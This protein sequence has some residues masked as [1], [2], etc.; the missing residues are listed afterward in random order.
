VALQNTRGV[1]ASRSEDI[2]IGGGVDVFLA[3]E[4][5]LQAAA[6]L[7]AI[8]GFSRAF[9][10]ARPERV[11]GSGRGG[12][13]S[14]VRDGLECSVDVWRVRETDGVLWLKISRGINGSQP[15]F[16]AAVT[17]RLIIV[18]NAPMMSRHGSRDLRKIRR[19]RVLW[20][21]F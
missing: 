1:L 9:S 16:L 21:M 8:P 18:E 4:I 6:T 3:T 13:A 17:C 11:A 19:K 15:L 20:A 12:V 5:W 2:S 7:P 14:Y 10:A